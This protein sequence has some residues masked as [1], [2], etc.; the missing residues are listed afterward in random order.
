[1][2]F[3]Q[4]DYQGNVNIGFYGLLTDGFALLA[5]EF[6][7]AA[8][9][10]DVTTTRIGGTDLVGLFAA[11]NSTRVL[12]PDIIEPHEE[13]VLDEAGVPYTVIASKFTALGNQVLCNDHGCVI[14]PNLEPVRDEIEEALGVDPVSSTVAGLDIPGSCGV[15]TND[16][17]LLHR[18]A[19]EEELERVEEAL[20]VDG[21]IGSVNF[22][23]PFVHSGILANTDDCFVG[24]DTK[25]PEIQRIQD[26]LGFLD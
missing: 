2:G 1:M 4:A 10:D 19:T 20:G 21:D 23:T 6:A 17:F 15:A 5:R 26:A 18:D 12:V 13:D 7:I 11:G 22:G 3:A 24:N 25:G 8:E 16:G 9:L 14:S